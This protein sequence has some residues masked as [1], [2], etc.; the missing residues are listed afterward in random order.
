MLRPPLQQHQK[1]PTT[2]AAST[3]PGYTSAGVVP[4]AIPPVRSIATASQNHAG[5]LP[6][7][8]QQAPRLMMPRLPSRNN[9]TMSAS[10]QPGSS[11]FTPVVSSL[12]GS[13]AAGATHPGLTRTASLAAA[14]TAA[15]REASK[16]PPPPPPHPGMISQFAPLRTLKPLADAAQRL[17]SN[18]HR[19]KSMASIKSYMT[20]FSVINR[21]NLKRFGKSK[22]TY[23]VIN[24]IVCWERDR[25]RGDSEG[26]GILTL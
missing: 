25:Q 4:S 1:L 22:I 14:A 20:T 21:K 9:I 18:D 17:R 19:R 16:Q 10:H 12:S 7:Q 26:R 23:L 2:T 3:F 6:Q 5:G 15:S 24:G 13:A 8:S 11:G